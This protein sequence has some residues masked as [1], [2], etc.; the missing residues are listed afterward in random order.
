MLLETC[1]SKTD[2]Y[3]GNRLSLSEVSEKVKA[4]RKVSYSRTQDTKKTFAACLKTL[5][6]FPDCFVL[7]GGGCRSGFAKGR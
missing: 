4:V 1:C 2:D 5:G 3:L 7:R 6:F